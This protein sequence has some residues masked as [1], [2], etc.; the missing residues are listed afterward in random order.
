MCE[1]QYDD[2][3]PLSRK[4][5]A[6]MF[7]LLFSEV[8]AVFGLLASLIEHKLWPLLP[9]AVGI[10]LLRWCFRAACKAD[11]YVQQPHPLWKTQVQMHV[12][13]PVEVSENAWIDI[14]K[15][16]PSPSDAALYI[17]KMSSNFKTLK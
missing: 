16:Y 1:C 15:R 14:Q 11:A 7:L 4:G 9:L 3:K 8:L 5:V 2:Q 13:F 10:F 17:L 6:V 12:G